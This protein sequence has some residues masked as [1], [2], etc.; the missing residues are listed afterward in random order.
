MVHRLEF[1][2]FCGLRVVLAMRARFLTN[3]RFAIVHTYSDCLDNL[4]CPLQGSHVALALTCTRHT[5][6][7]YLL[8]GHAR[9]FADTRG[10]R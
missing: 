4:N 8:A 3:R 1:T 6:L 10:D 5:P 2:E 9:I 7:R